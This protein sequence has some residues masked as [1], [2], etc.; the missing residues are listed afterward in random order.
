[1]LQSVANQNAGM[2]SHSSVQTAS[3]ATHADTSLSSFSFLPV[4]I[5]FVCAALTN[6]IPAVT[7]TVT[8]PE[9][10]VVASATSPESGN[11]PVWHESPDSESPVTKTEVATTAEALTNEERLPAAPATNGSVPSTAVTPATPVS[12]Q[13]ADHS[14]ISPTNCTPREAAALERTFSHHLRESKVADLS[15]L[16]RRFSTPDVT[17]PTPVKSDDSVR[18][19]EGRSLSNDDVGPSA[20]HTGADGDGNPPAEDEDE[21]TPAVSGN[22]AEQNR[23]D[24]GCDENL[25]QQSETVGEEIRHS[26]PPSIPQLIRP[27]SRASDTTI[28]DSSDDN[29]SFSEERTIRILKRRMTRHSKVRSKLL[30]VLHGVFASCVTS[31]FSPNV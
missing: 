6:F 27:T 16:V 17:C 29:L 25:N 3:S 4:P 1:M 20:D 11:S 2:I 28:S 24:H 14:I 31:T 12:T 10:E 30:V 7:V 5:V 19:S 18:G 23:G 26:Q 22:E 13:D 9:R 21:A 8:T 15:D